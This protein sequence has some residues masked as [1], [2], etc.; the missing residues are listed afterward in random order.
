MPNVRDTREKYTSQCIRLF[1]SYEK[2]LTQ[3]TRREKSR[4]SYRRNSFGDD[5]TWTRESL[6]CEALG[7]IEG[8][9]NVTLKTSGAPLY[10]S[11][12]F[13]DN[14]FCLSGL[15]VRSLAVSLCFWHRFPPLFLSSKPP[16]PLNRS[17][18]LSTSTRELFLSS[19]CASFTLSPSSSLSPVFSSSLSFAL[20]L[21]FYPVITSP[22]TF[23]DLPITVLSR[24]NGVAASG[25]TTSVYRRLT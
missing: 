17:S 14:C 23:I 24:Y 2:F 5:R 19:Y 10:Q 12:P 25:P 21:S 7:T 22:I 1:F 13:L 15:A 16:Y 3:R 11:F 20:S 8:G 9:F 6:S 18:L 4:V